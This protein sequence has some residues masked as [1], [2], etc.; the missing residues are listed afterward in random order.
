MIAAFGLPVLALA[1]LTHTL[2]VAFAGGALL[3]LGVYRWAFEPF[4]V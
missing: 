4:E 1:P 2:W 3:L